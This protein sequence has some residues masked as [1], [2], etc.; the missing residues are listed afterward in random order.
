MEKAIH[1][2][3]ASLPVFEVTPLESRIQ[4]ASF[5]ARMA[6]TLAGIF[7]LVALILAGVGIYGV[8]AYTTT[9]RTRE[10]GIHLALGAGRATIFRMVMIQGLRVVAIGVVIGLGLSLVL[11]RFLSG[12]LIGVH[13]IDVFTFVGVTLLMSAVAL[14]ACYVP[15]HR[16]MRI[17]PMLVLRCQ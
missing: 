2:L 1:D 3:N 13:T 15:A 17:D 4:F 6:G 7:G 9:Q 14:V 8:I 12:L 11:T 10:I 5:A 16:A